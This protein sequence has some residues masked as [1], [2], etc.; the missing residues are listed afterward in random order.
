MKVEVLESAFEEVHRLLPGARP[1]C[2]LVLGSGWGGVADEL[3]I[4]EAVDYESIPHLGKTGV[5]GHAGRLLL[6]R[7]SDAEVLLFQGRR[8]WY[9]GAGWEPIAIPVYITLRLGATVLILTN[10]AGGI[11]EDLVPGSLMVIDDHINAMGVSPLIGEPGP[12]W[13]PRFPDQ[14]SVYDSGLRRCLDEAAD[15]RLAHGVYLAG[16]GPAY[17]TPAEV[18]AY[19][20]LGADAVGMST[21][22]EAMLANAAGLRVAAISCITNRAAG[23]SDSRLTHDE[24][25]E[26]TRSAQPRMGAL[27]AKLIRDLSSRHRR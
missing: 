15:E 10:A 16:T 26:Q 2:A 6:A 4:A 21:V 13:G 23:L 8:H 1:L 11:R 24:V 25:I 9:E 20:A 14:S 7:S 22:P 27:L 18:R 19:R 5:K 3:D 12:V 17:E